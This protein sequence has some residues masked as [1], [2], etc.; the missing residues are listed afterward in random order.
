MFEMKDLE[1]HFGKT[2]QINGMTFTL[3]KE[4]A[5]SGVLAV[6]IGEIYRIY[7]TP[8]YE[9]V[10]IPVH[11][12]DFNNEEIGTDSYNVE[13]FDYERYCKVVKTLSENIIRINR[14]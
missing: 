6:W 2:M 8:Y 12:V 7:A 13:I 14:M 5:L 10:S 4:E 3:E 1:T 9:G 11:I